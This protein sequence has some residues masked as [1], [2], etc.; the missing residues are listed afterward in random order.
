MK[1]NL[2]LLARIIGSM[3]ADD[4]AWVRCS[5]EPGNPS[6]LEVF[7]ETSGCFSFGVYDVVD[8]EREVVLSGRAVQDEDGLM[9]IEP[10]DYAKY[11]SFVEASRAF[12]L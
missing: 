11:Q 3:S 6:T 9:V 8:G 7:R 10:E 12:P 1:I 2:P 4:D 5:A